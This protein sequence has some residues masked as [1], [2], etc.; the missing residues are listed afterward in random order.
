MFKPIVRMVAAVLV[1]SIIALAITAASAVLAM[2]GNGPK[3]ALSH[4]AGKGDRLRVPVKGTACSRQS[5][6]NFEPRCELD[7]REAAG[8]AR[9]VRIIAFQ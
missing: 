5:W 7:V 8:E 1:A 4:L 9:I 2:N 3:L 6:P